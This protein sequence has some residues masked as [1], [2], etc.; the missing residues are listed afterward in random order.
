MDDEAM[1]SR[2]RRRDRRGGL[3]RRGFLQLAGVGSLLTGLAACTTPVAPVAVPA[4]P[5][6]AGRPAGQ[7]TTVHFHVRSGVYGD[8]VSARAVDFHEAYP[9]VDLKVEVSPPLGYLPR[10]EARMAEA[11]A[12]DAFW[13]PF[14]SGDFH[15]LAQAGRLAPLAAWMAQ[16]ETAGNPYL[17]PA[18]DAATF[19]GQPMAL[20]WA[21]HPGRIGCYVNLDL[22]AAA[23]Q[24]PPPPDGDWTWDDLR[25]LALAATR[26]EAGSVTAYG[27]NL[28]LTLPHVLILIRSLGGEFYNAYGNRALLQSPPVLDAL[29]LLHGLMHVDGAMPTPDARSAYAFEQGNV[30]L[31]QNGYWGAWI[32]ETQVAVD[33]DFGVVPLPSGPDGRSGSMLEIEPLCLLRRS[34]VQAEAWNWL[35]FLTDRNTGVALATQGGVPGAR[36]DVWQDDSLQRPAH[37]VFA[38]AMAHVEAY[39]GPANLRTKEIS[40]VFDEG[41]AACWLGGEEPDRI[42]T[43][44]EARLNTHLAQGPA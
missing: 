2:P 33:F 10:L 40:G 41:M 34:S 35:R 15:R 22:L 3:S 13:L 24:D 9:D 42:V 19:Q 25:S 20:P 6:A 39:T 11:T 44:L 14:D 32:A 28:G 23:G 18:L 30:A 43:A 1:A 29:T 36:A 16:L 12:A 8:A 27:V 21:C 7:P 5:A 38:Q 26:T 4:D 17:Q 37:A 31:S